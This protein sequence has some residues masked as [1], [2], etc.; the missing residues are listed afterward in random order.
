MPLAALR[1]FATRLN[2]FVSRSNFP[3]CTSSCSDFASCTASIKRSHQKR[4]DVTDRQAS[5]A[6]GRRPRS[7][8]RAFE[9][10]HAKRLARAQDLANELTVVIRDA[11]Q[12]MLPS[13]I[14]TVNSWRSALT[15]MDE[16]RKVAADELAAEGWAISLFARSC[17]AH[18]PHLVGSS[19]L[20]HIDARARVLLADMLAKV[21]G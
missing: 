16:A 6:R 4:G 21:S 18:D 17:G 13:L 7:Q 11:R 12:A 15:K 14:A 9:A 19:V 10:K 3:T 2:R 1:Q 5:G 20:P 8:I